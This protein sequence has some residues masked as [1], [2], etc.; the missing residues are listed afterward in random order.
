MVTE[1][2]LV[3]LPIEILR[4]AERNIQGEDERTPAGFRRIGCCGLLLKVNEERCG[5]ALT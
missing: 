1:T 5:E 2:V 3:E 4:I